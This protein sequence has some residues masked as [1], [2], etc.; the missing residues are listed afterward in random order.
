MGGVEGKTP[1]RK[2]L[3]NPL[4]K[5]SGQAILEYIL[6]LIIMLSLGSILIGGIQKSRDKLWKQMLCDV[7]RACPKCAIPETV[8]NALPR[9]G[10][11]CK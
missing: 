2:R 1:A 11:N 5:N 3:S 10:V 9:S 4:K 7:S 6:L 8:K